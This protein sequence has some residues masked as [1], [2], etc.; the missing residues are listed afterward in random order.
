MI[1]RLPFR[2]K[3]LKHVSVMLEPMRFVQVL[4]E[5]SSFSVYSVYKSLKSH[6]LFSFI[7]CQTVLRHCCH[8]ALQWLA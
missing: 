8:N 1:H 7:C 5:H 2:E 6:L 4:H 3:K